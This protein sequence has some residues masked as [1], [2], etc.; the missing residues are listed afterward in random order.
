MQ[1]PGRTARFPIQDALAI[2][3]VLAI[4]NKDTD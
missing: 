2:V 3:Y 4:L 1:I